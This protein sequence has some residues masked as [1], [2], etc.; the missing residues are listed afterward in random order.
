MCGCWM[1]VCF[2]DSFNSP[3]GGN[4][5]SEKLCRVVLC[6]VV[7]MEKVLINISDKNLR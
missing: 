5:I 4:I 1:A 6:C 3:E 2:L 7:T